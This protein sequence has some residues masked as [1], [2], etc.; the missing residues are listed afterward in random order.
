MAS[1]CKNARPFGHV[2]GCQCDPCLV[3]AACDCAGCWMSNQQEVRI[4]E[5]GKDFV[6]YIEGLAKRLV[7][8]NMNDDQLAELISLATYA[9]KDFAAQKQNQNASSRT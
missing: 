9:F 7:L 1:F 4:Y 3:F 2:F 5:H 6:A 8:E